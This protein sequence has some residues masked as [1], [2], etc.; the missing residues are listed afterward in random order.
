MFLAA[1][2]KRF[3]GFTAQKLKKLLRV[4]TIFQFCRALAIPRSIR[5]YALLLDVLLQLKQVPTIYITKSQLLSVCPLLRYDVL[6]VESNSVPLYR[7]WIVVGVTRSSR[8]YS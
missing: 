8:C 6:Y 3:Y 4:S 7:F 5:F 2:S 1:N